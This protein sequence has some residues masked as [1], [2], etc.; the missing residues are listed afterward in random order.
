M[1]AAALEPSRLRPKRAPSSSAQLTSLSVSGR[2]SGACARSTSRPARTLRIPSSHPPLGTESRCPPMIT[3]RSESPGAV[4][5]MLPAASLSTLTPSMAAS[6]VAEPVV[7]RLPGVGPRDALG[8]VVVAGQ[9]LE[10]AQ[11]RND[12]AGVDRCHAGNLTPRGRGRP[13]S[14]SSQLLPR[15]LHGG[16]PSLPACPRRLPPPRTPTSSAIACAHV[17]AGS[18]SSAAAS[19]PPPWPPSRSPSGRSRRTARSAAPRRPTRRRPTSGQSDTATTASVDARA[20]TTRRARAPRLASSLVEPE[21]LA[22]T[23]APRSAVTTSQS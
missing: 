3:K 16:A 2:D 9:A 11:V 18:R 21:L 17:P 6:C 19:S 14:A 23:R 22:R 1:P 10:L 8:A 12:S 4:A 5:Q 13:G 20:T 7:G 15:L